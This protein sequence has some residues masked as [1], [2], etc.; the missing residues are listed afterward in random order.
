MVEYKVYFVY[1]GVKS[2]VFYCYDFW[3]MLCLC[4]LFKVVINLIGEKI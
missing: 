1:L 4:L 3:Y 2:Y